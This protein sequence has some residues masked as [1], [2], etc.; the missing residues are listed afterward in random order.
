MSVAECDPN[1]IVT[2]PLDVGRLKFVRII[3]SRQDRQWILIQFPPSLDGFGRW[4]P[5]TQVRNGV[6][7]G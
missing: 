3:T 7:G 2:D 1:G 4:R 6:R 5:P